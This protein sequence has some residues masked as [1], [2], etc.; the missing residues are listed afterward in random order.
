MEVG[1]DLNWSCSVK[2]KKKLQAII[3]LSKWLDCSEVKSNKLLFKL[4]A[5][6]WQEKSPVLLSLMQW[7]RVN[8][9]ETVSY[10]NITE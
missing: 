5:N 7:I 1:Q 2:E 9:R 10:C 6:I 8:S 4:S 3:K